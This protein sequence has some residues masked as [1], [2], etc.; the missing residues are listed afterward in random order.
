MIGCQMNMYDYIRPRQHFRGILAAHKRHW[1]PQR[2]RVTP[3]FELCTQ[4]PLVCAW[5]E[6]AA[7]AMVRMAMPLG[8]ATPPATPRFQ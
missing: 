7:L 2:R 5:H 8:G 4:L 1:L 3:P 6:K